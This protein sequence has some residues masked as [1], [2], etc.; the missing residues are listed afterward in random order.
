[1]EE[2]ID[3]V[4]RQI[5]DEINKIKAKNLF[6][7]LKEIFENI[8]QAEH[9]I[10]VGTAVP[11]FE[12]HRGIKRKLAKLI[13]KVF[14][15]FAKIITTPQKYFNQNIVESLKSIGAILRQI[16][17]DSNRV[18]IL[19]ESIRNF[20]Q[21]QI[22]TIHTQERNHEDMK[23]KI[24]KIFSDLHILKQQ[25]FKRESWVSTS[26]QNQTSREG[27]LKS[28]KS[29]DLD[30]NIS[31]NEFDAMYKS[32]EDVFRGK[33]NEIKKRLEVYLPYIKAFA[34][35]VAKLEILDI[36]C[37][38]GEFLQLLNENTI[39]A[40]GVDENS[41][42]IKLCEEL[43]LQVYHSEI[44]SFLKSQKDGSFNC[45]TGFHIM[46]HLPLNKMLELMDQTY[47]VLQQGG[48][49]IFETPNPENFLVSSLYFYLDPTHIKPIVPDTFEFLLRDRGF[50]NIEIKRMQPRHEIGF[51]D[52]PHV[53]ELIQMANMEM[54]YSLIGYKPD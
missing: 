32:F 35:N 40:K 31:K 19:L 48:M 5:Q 47:R 36:G 44:F 43:G 29:I 46:E 37:G 39:P 4:M 24:E 30:S 51:T 22:E 33:R 9:N 1:V 2:K 41:F 10:Q 11:E 13:S 23:K 8:N 26:I 6:S 25:A 34:K 28:T 16:E 20:S 49:V 53:N 45:I 3:E 52:N 38:R 50:I 7:N 18:I 12:Y 27:T 14:L 42:M 15:H 54:D 17:T 21:R